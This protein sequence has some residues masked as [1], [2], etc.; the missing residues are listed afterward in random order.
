MVTSGFDSYYPN[1]V[2]RVVI[3]AHQEILGRSGLNAVLNL[4]GFPEFIDQHPANNQNRNFPTHFSSR[5]Q[6][7]IEEFYGPRGGRGVSLRIG[8]ACFQY[9]LREYGHMLGLTETAFRLMPMNARL[10]IGSTAFAEV[11]NKNTGQHLRMEDKET[12]LI[13]HIERCH[14]CMDRHSDEAACQLLVG[15]L[16]EAMIWLS[17][18]KFFHVEET[19]CIARGD[20]VCTIV[21]NKTPMS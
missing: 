11:L 20:A 12:D 5:M 13:C 3:Q 6:K 1:R 14:L 9:G 17:G 2:G 16:Q 10:K 15:L 18:G 21:I 7:A 19:N 8:R 4:A